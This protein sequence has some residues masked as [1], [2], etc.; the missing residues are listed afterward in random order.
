M[1]DVGCADEGDI[2]CIIEGDTSGGDIDGD[3]M[4]CD[5]EVCMG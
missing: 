5:T 1:A 3:G 4:G 2:G